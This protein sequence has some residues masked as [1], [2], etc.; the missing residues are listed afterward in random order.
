[1]KR[2]LKQLF[3]KKGTGAYLALTVLAIA[4]LA[5]ASDPSSKMAFAAGLEGP[6]VMQERKFPPP[7]P[8]PSPSSTST[9]ALA[10]TAP[11]LQRCKGPQRFIAPKETFNL[12]CDVVSPLGGSKM[13]V[14]PEIW[15]P[16]NGCITTVD[17]PHVVMVGNNFGVSATFTNRCGSGYMGSEGGLAWLIYQM[18]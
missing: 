2:K 15:V 7:P 6:I 16:G 12:T 11:T 8:P 17:K 13:L 9:A 18:Q 14:L 5:M 10:S 1:M 4:L 3:P